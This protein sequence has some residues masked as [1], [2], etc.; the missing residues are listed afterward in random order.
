[1]GGAFSLPEVKTTVRA[2]DTYGPQDVDRTY[3]HGACEL[4]PQ[5]GMR[6]FMTEGQRRDHI[7]KFHKRTMDAAQN[8]K[9][10]L[11]DLRVDAL[12]EKEEDLSWI[13][14]MV[15][16]L[17]TG[18]LSGAIGNA[19][20]RYN[21]GG[22]AREATNET[23]RLLLSD[24]ALDKLVKGPLGAAKKALEGKYKAT[25]NQPQRSKKGE[26]LSYI[27]ALVGEADRA[28]V[29]FRER[30]PASADDGELLALIDGMQIELHSK[31]HYKRALAAKLDRYHKSGVTSIG[32]KRA[33]HELEPVHGSGSVKVPAF[34]DQRVVWVTNRFAGSQRRLWFEKQDGHPGNPT[35]VRAGDPDWPAN[36]RLTFGPRDP[37]DEGPKLVAPVPEEFVEAALARHEA[38]WNEPPAELELDAFGRTTRRRGEPVASIER[39]MYDT[40]FGSDEDPT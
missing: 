31:E 22:V 13:A 19:L 25:Q 3:N 7:D 24:D 35:Y 37:M 34:R 38:V 17:A 29:T 6:C 39:V 33:Q 18:H 28:F 16:D 4:A 9:D 14:A 2:A 11:Q 32:R 27:G 1:M 30:A 36:G 12:L 26:S 10:A 8:Y 40:F 21:A 15:L 20:K 23:R 5:P